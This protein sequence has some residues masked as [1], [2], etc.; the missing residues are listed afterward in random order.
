MGFPDG[1]AG[2]ESAC[3]VGDAGDMGLIPGDRLEIAWR[4]KWQPTPLF[5]PVKSHGQRNLASFSP[6]G[7]KESD[8]TE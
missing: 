4:R 7:C 2:K 5:L 8:T 6:W 3:I 1:S